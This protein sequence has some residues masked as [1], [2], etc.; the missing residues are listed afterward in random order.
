MEQSTR[1][2]ILRHPMVRLPHPGP[3]EPSPEHV[4]LYATAAWLRSAPLVTANLSPVEALELA[5]DLIHYAR[6]ILKQRQS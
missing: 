4:E 2:K 5:G 6:L 1:E 3:G